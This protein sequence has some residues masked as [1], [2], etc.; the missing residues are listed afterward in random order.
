LRFFFSLK[1]IDRTPPSLSLASRFR[2]AFVVNFLAA[3]LAPSE[4]SK[5]PSLSPV[6]VPL[7]FCCFVSPQ[8]PPLPS[9]R[10]VRLTGSLFPFPL[11]FSPSLDDRWE[12][13]PPD[14]PQLMCR[15]AWR[16]TPLTLRS[17]LLAPEK[18][19]CLSSLFWF[20]GTSFPFPPKIYPYLRCTST[21]QPRKLPPDASPATLMRNCLESLNSLI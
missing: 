5:R 3:E 2:G 11:F 7:P 19:R 16:F 4:F 8:F 14:S 20:F 9:K 15:F 21:L 1:V 17:A 18:L 10:K 13:L 12:M 6:C